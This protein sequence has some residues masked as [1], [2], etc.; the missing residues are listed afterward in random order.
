MFRTKWSLATLSA[1]LMAGGLTIIFVRLNL[2][3]YQD[4]HIG[5]AYDSAFDDRFWKVFFLGSGFY[6]LGALGLG[7]FLT[8][9]IA[10]FAGAICAVASIVLYW[11]PYVVFYADFEG[12]SGAATTTMALTVLVGGTLTWLIGMIR[13]S[14]PRSTKLSPHR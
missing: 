11:V 2:A 12:W 7:K 4:S 3:F 10:T 5:G 1:L 6:L 13:R 9:R 8:A 14:R